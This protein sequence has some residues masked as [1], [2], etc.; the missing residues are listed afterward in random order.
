MH[1]VLESGGGGEVTHWTAQDLAEYEA[2]RMKGQD[3]NNQISPYADCD[4][5]P[6][7]ALQ[8]KIKAYCKGQGW[9]VLSFPQ[10]QAVKRYLPEGWPDIVLILPKRVLFLEL[11]AAKGRKSKGQVLMA[12]MFEYLGHTIHEVRSYKQFFRLLK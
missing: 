7:S 8:S 5:G 9:P 10:T 4:T 11:K 1:E 6:E 12:Q 2:K 3:I